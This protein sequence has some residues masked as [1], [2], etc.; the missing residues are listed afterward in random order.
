MKIVYIMAQG[1]QLVFC[2]TSDLY[3]VIIW[4]NMKGQQSH[5]QGTKVVLSKIVFEAISK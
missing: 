2:Y 5:I 4:E 3:I 1:C